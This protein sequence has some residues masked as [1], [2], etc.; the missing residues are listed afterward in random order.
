MI[1]EEIQY[2][3]I[4]DWENYYISKCGKILSTKYKTPRVLKFFTNK[5]D[6]YKI[7]VLCS[8]GKTKGMLVHRLVTKAFLQDYTE[9]LHVDH[10]DNDKTNNNLTN[11][12][13]VTVSDNS[14]NCLK[15]SGVCKIFVKRDGT[16]RY[17]TSWYD[18]IGKRHHKSFS[19]NKYGEEL[20]KQK[21]TELRQEMV[22]KYYNRPSLS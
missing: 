4:P 2:Y 14:R 10:K 5:K 20:A 8:N 16:C 7:V 19:V 1:F 11:L 17:C 12:R 9:D 13:M 21:A 3:N 6:G 22:T 15:F 18:D